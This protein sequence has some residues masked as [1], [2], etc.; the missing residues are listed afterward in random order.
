MIQR[1]LE[2]VVADSL[3]AAPVTLVT[4]ARQVGKSTLVQRLAKGPWGGKVFT[5][6]DRTVLDAVLR[7]P[8]GWLESRDGPI[9]IDE[10]QRAPDLLRA[11]K[12][13]VDLDR[14]NGR[15]LLTGSANIMTL[16]RVSE[17][18]AGR[19]FLHELH[20]FSSS[21]LERQDP[22]SVIS[23]LFRSPDAASFLK[24]L[25]A[26]KPFSFDR[27]RRR[28]IRG[29]YPT[30]ALMENERNRA[31]WFESYRTTYIE[32]DIR[33]LSQVEHQPDFNRLIT[34]LAAR[35]GQLLNTANIS[36]DLGLPYT[37]LRRYLNLLEMTYQIFLLPSYST[38]VGTRVLRAPKLFFSDTGAACHAVAADSWDAL[39]RQGNVGSML[40]TW[41]GNEL[42]KMVSI[43]NVPTHLFGWRT[44]LGREIDFLLMRGENLVAIE[45]K[46]AKHIYS[47]DRGGLDAGRQNLGKKLGLAVILYTGTE[48]MVLDRHTAVVPMGLFFGGKETASRF[49]ESVD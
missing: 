44:P 11:I 46:M 25:S 35:T 34:L 12:R 24:S 36:R 5:L 32:R 39:E 18:L 23:D 42:R 15:F 4:G 48:A 13:M 17:T 14:R 47:K 40:E 31:K 33:E 19:V 30:P 27:I 37:T 9:V 21:E 7:D 28:I 10:V 6:D 49:T 16:S 38:N 26:V 8:D 2:S 3:G 45:V 43:Q 22:S 1:H 29:G 41:V 20:P